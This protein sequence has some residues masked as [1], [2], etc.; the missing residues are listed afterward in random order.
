M[1]FFL[2]LT[3]HTVT[4]DKREAAQSIPFIT[5]YWERRKTACVRMLALPLDKEKETLNFPAHWLADA[6]GARVLHISPEASCWHQDKIKFKF[7]EGTCGSERI[8][9]SAN[10]ALAG[11]CWNSKWNHH[12]RGKKHGNK[13]Q[14]RKVVRITVPAP[15]ELR[16]IEFRITKKRKSRS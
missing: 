12:Q 14:T 8:M 4:A 6:A 11:G 7:E 5:A 10:P 1:N 15:Y 9:K 13:K 16:S 3:K 2:H